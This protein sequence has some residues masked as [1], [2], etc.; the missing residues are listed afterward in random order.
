MTPSWHPSAAAGSRADFNTAE[1]QVARFEQLRAGHPA[2][3]LGL[4]V[5]M[6]FELPSRARPT[7]ILKRDS[8]ELIYSPLFKLSPAREGHGRLALARHLLGPA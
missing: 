5:R 7:L 3:L 6:P 4:S 8:S 2:E 1:F